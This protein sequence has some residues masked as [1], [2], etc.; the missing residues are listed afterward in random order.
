MQKYHIPKTLVEAFRCYAPI[1]FTII[2]KM[3]IDYIDGSFTP[4]DYGQ[5]WIDLF[6]PIR[7]EIDAGNKKKK[8]GP[9][10]L[11]YPF[12]TPEF[13]E[14]WQLL[15]TQPKWSNKTQA[16]LQLSLNRIS[17]FAKSNVNDAI[18][19]ITNSIAGGYQGVFELKNKP[20]HAKQPTNAD[21]IWRR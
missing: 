21:P 2:F 9:V 4:T 13:M 20:T 7:A 15:L 3:T 8:K 6:A 12:D 1:S 18:E 10:N 16:A 11:V 17:V 14:A 5:D 19:I